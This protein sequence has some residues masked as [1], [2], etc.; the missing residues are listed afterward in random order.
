[1]KR[2]A[3]SQFS[4]NRLTLITIQLCRP[5]ED[6]GCRGRFPDGLPFL[7]RFALGCR[8]RHVDQNHTAS[9]PLL[10]G[11]F[12]TQ[13][14]LRVMQLLRKR[15]LCP[16][17]Q[18]IRSLISRKRMTNH[19]L[20]IEV[21]ESS[22]LKQCGTTARTVKDPAVQSDTL[23]NRRQSTFQTSLLQPIKQLEVMK[24][25]FTYPTSTPK[26]HKSPQAG[27]DWSARC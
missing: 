21:L 24:H 18:P 14:T 17:A 27:F 10:S 6:Y 5:A 26:H 25:F 22:G 12:G 3:R 1:M 7:R 23:L 9:P 4:L 13:I 19:D 11:Q 20:V 8:G 16:S 2:T 15:P